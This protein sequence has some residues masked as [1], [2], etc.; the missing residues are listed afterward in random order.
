ME[1]NRREIFRYLGYKR[2]EADD[3]TRA[4]AESCLNELEQAADPRTMV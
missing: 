2:D 4:L 3:R 1:V